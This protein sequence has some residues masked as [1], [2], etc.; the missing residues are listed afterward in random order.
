[1]G[2][3]PSIKKKKYIFCGE[4][5]DLKQKIIS[6]PYYCRRGKQYTKTNTFGKLCVEITLPPSL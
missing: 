3:S 5:T 2:L 6:D 4:T 1:M